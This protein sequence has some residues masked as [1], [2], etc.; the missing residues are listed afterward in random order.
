[1]ALYFIT[2]ED[3]VNQIFEDYLDDSLED[4]LEILEKIELENISLM[5][6][7]LRDR[8]DVSKIFSSEDYEDKPLIR[9]ILS[10]LI[11]YAV[12]K[13]NKARKIP[14]TFSD[15]YKWAMAWLKDVKDGKET[16]VFPVLENSRK[17]VKW[18]NNR[19]S[20]LYI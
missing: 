19:N 16:P 7:K 18:G 17:E 20:D 15:E 8:Y 9:K 14:S 11:N 5:K 10:S 1:M 3:L 2:K 6:G 13:R 4:D 12:V